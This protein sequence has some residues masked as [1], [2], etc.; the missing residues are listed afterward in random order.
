VF[1]ISLNKSIEKF[2]VQITDILGKEILNQEIDTYIEES[3]KDIRINVEK[4]TYILN[5]KNQNFHEQRM[6]IIN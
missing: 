5:V 1:S 3:Y 6:I 4:G 2:N